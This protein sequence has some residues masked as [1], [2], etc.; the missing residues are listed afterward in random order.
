MLLVRDTTSAF[1]DDTM[2]VETGDIKKGA[3]HA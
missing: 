2:V 1:F 3:Y